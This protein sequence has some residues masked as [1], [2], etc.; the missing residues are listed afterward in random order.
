MAKRRRKKKKKVVP[1]VFVE[2]TDKDLLM[3]KAYGGQAKA[4]VKKKIMP[5]HQN[6]RMTATPAS[7]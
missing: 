3:A 6:A 1:D 7:M 4:T 5:P 2:P